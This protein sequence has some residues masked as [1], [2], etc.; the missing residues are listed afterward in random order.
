MPTVERTIHEPWQELI[1][2]AEHQRH[3][4]T[5]AAFAAL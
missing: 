5:L 1:L 2:D 4:A 3:P